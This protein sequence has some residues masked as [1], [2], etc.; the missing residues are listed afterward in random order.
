MVNDNKS[1]T[2]KIIIKKV[3]KVAPVVRQAKN[4]YI[5]GGEIDK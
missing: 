3:K 4:G 1:K 5:G 2:K